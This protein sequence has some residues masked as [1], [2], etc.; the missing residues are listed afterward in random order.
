MDY[1]ASLSFA[2]IHDREDILGGYQ[3]KFFL[4]TGLARDGKTIT[5]LAGASLG[6]QPK[7]ASDFVED[8][9]DRWARFATKANT[10]GDE[11]WNNLPKRL[12]QSVSKIIGAET[13]ETVVAGS[14]STNLLHLLA[15]FYKPSDDRKIILIDH[16]THP[17]IERSIR[18]IVCANGLDP[19][20]VIVKLT[21]DTGEYTL[22][23][24]QITETIGSYGQEIAIVLLEGVN[25][26]TGQYF[27]LET[28]GKAIEQVNAVFG[29]QLDHA[30][31]NVPLLLNEWNVDFATWTSSKFLNAGPN[32]PGGFFVHKKNHNSSYKPQISSF[33]DWELDQVSLNSEG[34]EAWLMQNENILGLAPLLASLELFDDTGI[35]PLRKRSRNLTGYLEFMIQRADPDYEIFEIITPDN[36]KWRGSQLTIAVHGGYGK[37]IFESLKA[38]SVICNFRPETED[39]FP[40]VIQMTPVAFYNTYIDILRAGETLRIMLETL[41][42]KMG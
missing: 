41:K 22:S 8:E 30:I 1:Q 27:D 20:D 29:V 14:S 23:T 17:T 39:G 31:G 3:S 32:A 36:Q 34:A 19:K 11:N 12:S 18:T 28:I 16:L 35:M 38:A 42:K 5:Y 21:P 40:A 2:K 25:W 9:L 13:D 6:L 4:P 15:C 7:S 26:L 24:E 37:P 10:L 33:S